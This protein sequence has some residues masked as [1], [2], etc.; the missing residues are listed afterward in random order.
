MFK[1]FTT[2]YNLIRITGQQVSKECNTSMLKWWSF[3]KNFKVF[4]IVDNYSLVVVTRAEKTSSP[5]GKQTIH[6][7]ILRTLL[8]SI[9]K[10]LSCFQLGLCSVTTIFS[11]PPPPGGDPKGGRPVCLRSCTRFEH[12]ET[13]NRKKQHM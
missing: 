13:F 8:S 7:G 3:S 6:Y 12:T 2:M 9:E 4:S 11:L 10:L 5:Q 1:G